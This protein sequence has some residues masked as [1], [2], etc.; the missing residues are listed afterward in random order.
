MTGGV[1]SIYMEGMGP[2]VYGC[3][4][5]IYMEGR[6]RGVREVCLVYTWKVWILVLGTCV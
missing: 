3:V 6:D 1:S 2:G 5:S 4:S